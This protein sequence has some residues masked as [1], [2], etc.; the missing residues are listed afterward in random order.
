MKRFVKLRVNSKKILRRESLKRFLVSDLEK[1]IATTH[2]EL[3]GKNALNKKLSD[4]FHVAKHFFLVFDLGFETFFSVF[5]FLE[6]LRRH[7][8]PCNIW[9]F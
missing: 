1:L 2:D 5:N 7:E 9:K 6:M 4:Q 3:G 8:V